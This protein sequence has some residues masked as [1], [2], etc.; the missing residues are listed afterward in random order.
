MAKVKNL[1]KMLEIFAKFRQVQKSVFMRFLLPNILTLK[2]IFL[3][4]FGR[5]RE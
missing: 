1:P 2:T 3:T 5:L 4:K